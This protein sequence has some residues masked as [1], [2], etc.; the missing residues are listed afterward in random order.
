[1]EE[2][3]V[4]IDVE[5]DMIFKEKFLRSVFVEVLVLSKKRDVKVVFIDFKESGKVEFC[6]ICYYVK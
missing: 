1:M 2:F 4:S 3:I 5:N 6:V